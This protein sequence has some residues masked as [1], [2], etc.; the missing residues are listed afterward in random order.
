MLTIDH[1]GK[2]SLHE[3]RQLYLTLKN[4]IFAKARL[5]FAY[6]SS[7]LEMILKDVL[8]EKTVM[9]DIQKPR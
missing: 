7:A 2:K 6:N 8:G 9:S 1:P 5:G 3:L 4:K